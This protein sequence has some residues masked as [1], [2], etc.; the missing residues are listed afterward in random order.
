MEVNV[1]KP[2]IAQA[3]HSRRII[4]DLVQNPIQ[5]NVFALKY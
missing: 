1:S 4:N 5:E 2:N 3:C